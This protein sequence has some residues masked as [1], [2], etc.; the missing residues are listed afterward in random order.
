M[1]LVSNNIITTVPKK[2]PL[3]PLPVLR[4]DEYT[5]E[6]V[7]WS[8]GNKLTRE[9]VP[10]SLNFYKENAKAI[11]FG[12]GISRSETDINKILQS[13]SKKI[14]NYYN[15]IYSCN[16]AFKDIKSDFIIVTNKLLSTTVPADLH[17]IVYATPEIHRIYRKTRMIPFNPGLDAGTTAA[18]IACMHGASKVFL[19]GFDGCP[20]GKSIN[21]YNGEKFYPTAE[22]PVNDE[23]WQENLYR[24]IIAYPNTMFY[25]IN[26]EPPNA[27][28]LHRLPNYKVIDN[29][30]FVSLADI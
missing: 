6:W 15:I 10:N 28:L 12:N 2:Q 29:R 16:A 9:F 25:R 22:T 20:S 17:P 19:I 14:I 11:I 30:M 8:I 18:Y 3:N 13:N 24:L 26:S 21:L 4:N 7:N 5:G 23:V 1:S 27:R